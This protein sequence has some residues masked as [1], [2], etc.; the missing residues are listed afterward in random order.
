MFQ[1]KDQDKNPRRQISEVET[2]DL[3][4][5][6]FAVMIIKMNSGKKKMEAQTKQVQEMYNKELENINNRVQQ[7]NN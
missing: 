4:E 2:E 6:V 5:K 7:H 1:T 3:P